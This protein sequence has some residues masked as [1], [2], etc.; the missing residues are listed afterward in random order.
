MA[1]AVGVEPVLYVFLEGRGPSLCTAH[2]TTARSPWLV[3]MTLAPHRH[4]PRPA[5]IARRVVNLP[6]IHLEKRGNELNEPV[7]HLLQ[8]RRVTAESPFLNGDWAMLF[9]NS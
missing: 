1:I 4:Q 3:G 2:F 9:R 8:L 5:R 6:M 7:H